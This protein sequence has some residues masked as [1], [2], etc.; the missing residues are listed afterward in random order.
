MPVITGSGGT[1]TEGKSDRIGLPTGTSDPGSAA[2]GDMYYK[3]DDKKVRVYDGSE[4]TDLAGGASEGTYTGGIGNDQYY[5]NVTLHLKASTNILADITNQ[6]SGGCMDLSR[7]GQIVTSKPNVTID[8]SN[9]KFEDGCFNLDSSDGTNRYLRIKNLNDDT[10]MMK[11]DQFTIEFWLWINSSDTNVNMNARVFQLGT[12]ATNGVCLLYDGSNLNFGRTD[13][14]GYLTHARSNYNDQWCHVAIVRGS[15]HL[16]MFRNGSQ[17]D[18]YNGSNWNWDM[19]NGEDFFFGL[20][21][22]LLNST[23]SNIKIDDIRITKGVARYNSSGYTPPTTAYPQYLQ[24][25]TTWGTRS[26]PATNAE[27]I[28]TE[29]SGTPADGVYYVK[30]GSDIVRTHCEFNSHGGWMLIG[31]G[32][33]GG[34][35]IPTGNNDGWSTLKFGG[36][37]RARQIDSVINNMTWTHCWMG[38][39]D[40]N[41]DEAWSN[42]EKGNSSMD[43]GRQ[44]FTTSGT[45]FNVGFNTNNNTYTSGS[46]DNGRNQQWSYKGPGGS[47][48]SSLVDSQRQN[49]TVI[50]G[51]GTTDWNIQNTNTYGISPHDA[52]IGGAW[53]W[54][55]NG[56]DG[57][58]N[59]NNGFDG[60]HNNVPWDDRYSYWFVK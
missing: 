30:S 57:G 33:G 55:S 4:W 45:K 40:N 54:N 47:S 49:G 35:G 5:H 20:Y 1:G 56:T 39:T 13:G 44:I 46:T 18:S 15:T 51:A 7:A 19:N 6:P 32:S 9:T 60:D 58:G 34:T 16:R 48:G 43:P 3:T 37:N 41:S 25:T 17:V 24:N 11:Q 23:R 26:R 50:N 52:G 22:G 14:D 2:V 31:M 53:I 36:S 29:S 12:N 38:M 59:F 10:M 21:P 8:T 27:Q 42:Q 28:R